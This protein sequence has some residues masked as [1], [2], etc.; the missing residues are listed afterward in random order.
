MTKKSNRA[1]CAGLIR[2]LSLVLVVFGVIGLLSCTELMDYLTDFIQSPEIQNP[3]NQNQGTSKEET[4][5]PSLGNEHSLSD[6]LEVHFIDV[7]QADS[8]LIKNGKSAMLI[9]AGDSKSADTIKTY[10]VSQGVSKLEYLIGTH[11]HEDH[12]GSFADVIN[13]FDIE[14]IILTEKIN[15]G[16]YFKRAI[17]AIEKKNLSITKATVGDKYKLGDAEFI[18]LSPAKDYGDNLND[19]S[20]II[21]LTYGENSFIFTGDAET[22]SEKDVVDSGYELKSDVI[23]LGHHGSSTSSSNAFLKAVSPTYGVIM[24][25]KDNSY[26]H[27]HKETMEKIKKYGITVYRTDEQ[28]SIVAISDGK[29]ITWETGT[30]T[31]TA[32]ENV[33]FILNVNSKKFHL[34]SC[35]GIAKISKNNRREFTGSREELIAD[36]YSPCGT[37]K[38]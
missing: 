26:G 34:P 10:L 37:C 21:R 19:A 13:N 36:G 12:M 1:Q 25:G 29:N 18:I 5:E 22:T 16:K 38:P 4:Q 33:T 24:C 27:P 20:I 30:V 8:I 3:E 32:N 2:T 6:E 14:N 35:S 11:P 9:D 23:K 7:G 15:T 31:K 28:G 17:E